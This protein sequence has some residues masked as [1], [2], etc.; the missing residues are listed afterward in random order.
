MNYSVF[1]TRRSK[2]QEQ[3]W[4]A[5]L[6][7]VL[8]LKNRVCIDDVR[9][10]VPDP[11]DFELISKDIKI[12]LELTRLDR[13][14]F[15]KGGDFEIGTYRA[16][17]AAE[18]KAKRNI[19]QKFSWGKT[20][21]ADVVEALRRQLARKAATTAQFNSRYDELWLAFELANG[22]PAGSLVT[23][24]QVEGDQKI[25]DE[26]EKRF[27]FECSEI[28]AQKHPFAYVIFFCGLGFVAFK[29]RSRFELPAVD[30]SHLQAGS[31]L[32]PS[33]LNR[34][35]MMSTLATHR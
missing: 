29:K 1:Q 4:D 3:E 11:P 26:M 8:S 33:A 30:P 5:F 12:G 27:L 17:D 20:T 9:F 6:P 10:C 19:E 34:S 28:C 23:S 32:P 14:I 25:F 22:N 31:L 2:K 21:V 13:R 18:T 35:I 15:E 24:R 7:L 16:W